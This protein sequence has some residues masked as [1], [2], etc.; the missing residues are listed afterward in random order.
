MPSQSIN[1]DNQMIRYNYSKYSSITF[2]LLLI[3]VHE[4]LDNFSEIDTERGDIMVFAIE[5][6]QR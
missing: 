1:T 6:M 4:M 2:A 5:S 3:E